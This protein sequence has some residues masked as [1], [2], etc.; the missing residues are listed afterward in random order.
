MTEQDSLA[1]ILVRSRVE[2]EYTMGALAHQT[3]V[4]A[5]TLR[6]WE[7]RYGFPTPA[8]TE[9]NQRRYSERDIAAVRWLR[10]QKERGQGIS[11][12]IAMVTS[13]LVAGPTTASERF[14][15]SF[16]TSTQ[17]PPLQGL[18][19]ALISGQLDAAQNAWDDI[20]VALSPGAIGSDVILPAHQRIEQTVGATTGT[21]PSRD[22]AHAFLLRKAT[23]LLDHAGPDAG[24]ISFCILTSGTQEDAVPAT[25][26]ATA[27][28]RAGFRLYT[29]F[30]NAA[31]LESVHA[32]HDLRPD[33]V[34]FVGGS[35][36]DARTVARL[37]P[38]Q[39]I[40]RWSPDPSTTP[41]QYPTILPASLTAVEAFFQQDH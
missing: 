41:D 16:N 22:R 13:R 1:E 29:P 12:A 23:V 35:A 32:L 14:P 30:L 38:G 33:H 24:Q 19:E 11:E 37:L 5:D 18:V 26:L 17:T 4:P 6:S 7:R 8:R 21:S 3:G 27:L 40:Y 2:P 36:D 10:A 34:I 15:D 9:T 31:S 39:C 20:V 25:V 28:A